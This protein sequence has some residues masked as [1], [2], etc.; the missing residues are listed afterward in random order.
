MASVRD[1]YPRLP[2]A[3]SRHRGVYRGGRSREP[4]IDSIPRRNIAW[5][6]LPMA[7]TVDPAGWPERGVMTAEVTEFETKIRLQ[8][9]TLSMTLGK[10]LGTALSRFGFRPDQEVVVRFG[11]ERLEIRPRNAP[12]QV[13]EK[14]RRAAE[15][16]KAVRE[17]VE[18][19]L[20]D[21]PPITDEELEEDSPRA[22][23]LGM[24]ECLLSDDLDPA[25][26][27]LD[28]AALSEDIPGPEGSFPARDRAAAPKPR[29][30]EPD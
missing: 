6:L 16:L 5:S 28:S 25:I 20:R 4:A 18:G 29:P 24:L 11:N 3:G 13:Q 7:V 8:G 1:G 19:L 21:L 17:R 14:L 22:E 30:P 12:E 27:K 15:E 26:A 23:L 9:R 10:S 2:G